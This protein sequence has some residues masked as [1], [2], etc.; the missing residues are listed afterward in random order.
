MGYSMPPEITPST[1]VMWGHGYGQSMSE[2]CSM[3]NRLNSAERSQ[4]A[5]PS[6]S[7][8]GR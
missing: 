6:R 2:R 3:E 8:S 1:A 5:S 7:P 4:G